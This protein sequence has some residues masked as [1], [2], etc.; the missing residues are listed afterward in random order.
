MMRMRMSLRQMVGRILPIVLC[1]SLSGCGG[2]REGN[3]SDP[4]A[5]RSAW[6]LD[7]EEVDATGG[8]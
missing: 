2:N 8:P 1:L 4:E 3:N 6:S 7:A 5:E